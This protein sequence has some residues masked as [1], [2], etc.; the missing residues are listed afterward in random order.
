MGSL[1]KR[2]RNIFTYL[3]VRYTPSSRK[4]VSIE[5]KRLC[6]FITENYDYDQ[7]L[8]ILKHLQSNLIEYSKNEIIKKYENIE[9]NKHDIDTITNNITKLDK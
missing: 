1:K 7:H 4:L 2:W 8:K 5:A 3:F 9:L 6:K